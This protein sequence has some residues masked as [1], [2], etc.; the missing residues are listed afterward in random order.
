M[1]N[2]LLNLIVGIMGSI[3]FGCSSNVKMAKSSYSQDVQYGDNR[4]RTKTFVY[5]DSEDLNSQPCSEPPSQ[6]K[7]S[8]FSDNSTLEEKYGPENYQPAAD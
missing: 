3:L 6:S 1:K 5:G 7:M 4:Q 2:I 8:T